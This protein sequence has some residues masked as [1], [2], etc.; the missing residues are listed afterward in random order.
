ME[1]RQQVPDIRSTADNVL[2]DLRADPGDTGQG[3]LDAIGT[4]TGLTEDDLIELVLEFAHR[5][6]GH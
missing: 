4:M 6:I 5:L 3:R 1:K 2:A